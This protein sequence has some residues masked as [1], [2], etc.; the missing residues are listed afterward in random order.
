[1]NEALKTDLYQLTMAQGYWKNGMAEKKAIF[2]LYFRKCPF[3]GNYAIFSGLQ[4]V[5]EFINN[6]KF[7]VDDVT[8]LQYL[9][10]NNGEP[11]FDFEFLR[12][13]TTMKFSC[14]ILQVS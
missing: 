8:Y 3:K 1:M 12:Y 11:L 4:S 7:S 5:I 6:F 9:E 14:T 10:G 2:N 13:L